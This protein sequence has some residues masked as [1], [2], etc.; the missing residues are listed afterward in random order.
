MRAVF[1]I[2][3]LVIATAGI[4]VPV[5]EAA[6][7]YALIEVLAKEPIEPTY[8]GFPIALR[9]RRIETIRNDDWNNSLDDRWNSSDA[10]RGDFREEFGAGLSRYL[11][12]RGFRLTSG[13]EGVDIKVSID[14]FEGRRRIRTDGGDLLGTLTLL[15]HGNVVGTKE[16]FESLNYRDESKERRIFTERYGFKRVSFD[17]VLFYR[18]SLR[19]YASVV[20]G[21]IDFAGVQPDLN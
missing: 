17:T 9:V 10:F 13:P 14:H 12:A 7:Q 19:F 18:L 1:V 4:V 15:R 16:L 6:G 5:V 8:R 11:A 20:E 3:S 2:M 21:I